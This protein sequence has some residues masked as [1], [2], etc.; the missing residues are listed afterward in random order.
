M[1]ENWKPIP[2]FSGRY[3]VSDLGRIRSWVPWRGQSSPRFLTPH[4]KGTSEHLMVNLRLNGKRVPTL[5][6]RA[7]LAG[8]IGDPPADRPITR[9]LDG[10]PVNNMLSNLAYGTPSENELD[11]VL[12]GTHQN[13]SKTHCPQGHPY[14]ATNTLTTISGGRWCRACS[15]ERGCRRTPC[16][17]CGEDKSAANL[18]RHIERHHAGEVA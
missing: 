11:K 16:P 12:H 6:H 13:A 8:F 3:D 1:S 7:V 15:R 5:V 18:G 2:G 14:D 4:S 17:V 9:H 10:N